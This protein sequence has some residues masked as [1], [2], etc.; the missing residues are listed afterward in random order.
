MTVMHKLRKVS[1]KSVI[2]IQFTLYENSVNLLFRETL[3]MLRTFCDS[4]QISVV[5]SFLVHLS[6]LRYCQHFG[7]VVF[8]FHNVYLGATIKK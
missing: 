4:V 1:E 6:F 5:F 3:V 8:R 2:L 7:S